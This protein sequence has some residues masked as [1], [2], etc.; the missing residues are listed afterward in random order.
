MRVKARARVLRGRDMIYQGGIATLRRFQDDVQEVGNGQE[1]G[2]RLEN[3][4]ELEVG[5]TIEV[6]LTENVAQGL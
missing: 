2:I 6:Y 3:F 1:C 4:N 5:D